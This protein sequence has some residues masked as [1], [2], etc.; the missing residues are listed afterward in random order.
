M[1][2]QIT[3]KKNEE[4]PMSRTLRFVPRL[5][6]LVLVFGVLLAPGYAQSINI[7][8]FLNGQQIFVPPKPIL[9][10]CPNP[11]APGASC[12]EPF[13]FATPDGRFT[14]LASWS[15]TNLQGMG[16]YETL[17]YLVIDNLAEP[18]GETHTLGIT[19]FQRY[20]LTGMSQP[21]SG[22]ALL[23]ATCGEGVAIGG[24]LPSFVD[25]DLYINGGFTTPGQQ[26][27]ALCASPFL[28][29]TTVSTLPIATLPW[30]MTTTFGAEVDFTF[31]SGSQANST[32]T[33]TMTAKFGPLSSLFQ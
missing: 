3:I 5:L 2:T 19:P 21:L 20:E 31:G 16:G 11:L 24:S 26:A 33:A 7:Q 12:A 28:N 10:A 13:K 4:T 6:L 23:T 27:N 32:E 18:G 1:K 8:E 29:A 25:D 17:T 30:Q 14:V 15:F 9:G 22:I